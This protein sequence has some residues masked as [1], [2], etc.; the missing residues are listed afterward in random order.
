LDSSDK[1]GKKYHF[2]ADLSG[3]IKAEMDFK[4]DRFIVGELQKSGIRILSEERSSG[5][6]NLS[7]ELRFILDPLD[8]TYNFVRGLA[9]SAISLAL[10]D[11]VKPV[12]GVIHLIHEGKTYW[13]GNNLGAFCD[14]T[15]IE[16]STN[17]PQSQAVV[18]TG[19]P[20]RVDKNKASVI[21]EVTSVAKQ[22]GKV[23][24]LGSAATSLINVARGSADYY[25]EDEIMIW[26]VAAGLA[27]VEGSGGQIN[28][29]PGSTDL[30]FKVK[31][32]NVDF[33]Y[34]FDG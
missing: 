32:S 31:A 17:V 25:F 16:V 24:M 27:I 28:I 23:R 33:S 8:G 22:F 4:L 2:S 29:T 9:E 5:E 20:V 14:G 13:G 21:E 6:K 18:C 15:I 19:F 3:E 11:G 10:W 34:L 12:F 30:S 7:K 1:N 26:D